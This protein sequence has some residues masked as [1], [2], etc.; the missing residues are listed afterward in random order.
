MAGPGRLRHNN[1]SNTAQEWDGIKC[2]QL[3][4]ISGS[5]A[6]P[7]ENWSIIIRLSARIDYISGQAGR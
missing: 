5:S 6:E 7:G 1:D 4:V 2:G 3:A